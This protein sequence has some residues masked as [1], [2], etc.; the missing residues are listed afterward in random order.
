[1]DALGMIETK[2]LIGT[3]E[4][5]DSML[6]AADVRLVDRV[7]VGS[8]IVTVTIQGDVGAVKA[9]VD[10]GAAA[11]NALSPEL[12]LSEHVI[13]RPDASLEG[14]V[15]THIAS[16]GP[17]NG[18][19]GEGPDPE[20]DGGNAPD[21]GPEESGNI[22]VESEAAPE[23]KEQAEGVEA[24]EPEA[25]AEEAAEPEPESEEAE[26]TETEE[27][28]EAAEAEPEEAEKSEDEGKEAKAA[29]PAVEEAT[30]TAVQEEPAAE[31]PEPAAE[32]PEEA[33]PAAEEAPAEESEPQ[34]EASE[35]AEDDSR[36]SNPIADDREGIAEV[37]AESGVDALDERL[38]GFRVSE[39]RKIARGYKGFSLSGRDISKANKK[40]LIEAIKEYYK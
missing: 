40:M 5:L 1:M 24:S 19:D 28:E 25:P 32:E 3:V 23:E 29:E 14:I 2:G 6:K 27:T 7:F 22:S 18:P 4:A 30:E 31:E 33:A 10:A 37:V 21:N 17:D 13:P 20:P 26:E 39:L 36:E 8:G 11:V 35:K 38:S 12:L 16:E 9:A 15:V 34:E